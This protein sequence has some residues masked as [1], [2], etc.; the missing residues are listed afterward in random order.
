[1][2]IGA[3]IEEAERVASRVKVAEVA[4]LFAGFTKTGMFRSSRASAVMLRRVF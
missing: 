4:T 2:Q 3:A 1:M